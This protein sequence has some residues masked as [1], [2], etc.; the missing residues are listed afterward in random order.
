MA[1]LTKGDILNARDLKTETV[2]V[3]EWGGDV[4]VR[5]MTGAERDAFASGLIDKDGKPQLT[6]YR[7]RLLATC[8][9]GEDGQRLFADS[10]IE[11]LAGKASPEA[12]SKLFGRLQ[13]RVELHAELRGRE[14]LER[15]LGLGG[16]CRLHLGPVDPLLR[17]LELRLDLPPAIHVADGKNL[18][19]GSPVPPFLS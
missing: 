11:A 7:H 3:P 8:I 10:D 18:I 6:G 9:V 15:P 13:D 14:G 2:A 5:T 12:A 16:G 1:L 4:I 17:E 19:S